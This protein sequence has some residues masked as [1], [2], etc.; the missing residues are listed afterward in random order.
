MKKVYTRQL[1]N[2]G[3]IVLNNRFVYQ[4]T[5]HKFSKNILEI[6]SGNRSTKIIREALR[7]KGFGHC[8]SLENNM[9]Y[10]KSVS[11][12]WPDD[13]SG[14]VQFSN[15]VYNSFGLVYDF[16]LTGKYDFIYLDGPGNATY[17]DSEGN[18]NM[19]SAKI[20]KYLSL[21]NLWL[22]PDRLFMGGGRIFILD[23]VKECFHED[24][25]LLVDSSAMA[26]FYYYQRYKD[27]FNFI[28]FG[29]PITSRKKKM[30][31]KDEHLK[32]VDKLGY[33]PAKIN[34]IYNKKSKKA[35]TIINEVIGAVLHLGE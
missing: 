35:P 1:E 3:K 11:G 32:T 26:M 31:I 33:V 23:Y 6:G 25:I 2:M 5:H 13:E 27:V 17:I 28:G 29:S 15:L 18:F 12:K 10:Y 24:T 30:L 21:K 4:F 9:D 22:K 8:L 19:G 14:R 7:N 16:K 34:I 20:K